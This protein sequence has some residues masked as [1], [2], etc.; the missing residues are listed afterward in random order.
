MKIAI[1]SDIH[2]NQ[3]AF[4]ALLQE[5][6]SLKV[7]YFFVLGDIVGYYYHPELIIEWIEEW[8]HLFIQGNHEMMLSR[9]IKG[10]LKEENIRQNYGSGIAQA[11]TN[12]PPATIEKLTNLPVTENVVIDNVRFQLSHGT[13]WDRDHY[14]YPD[15]PTTLLERC[16]SYEADFVFLGH[17]HRP[18]TFC[19]GNTVVTNVGSV[20][21]ARDKGGFASWV[22]VDTKNKA[23]QFHRTAY[24]ID[25]IL[26]QISVLDPEVPYLREVLQR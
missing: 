17:T 14:V 7:D 4:K 22:T 10:K 25:D 12:L 26:S 18:F 11:L 23:M 15:S 8:P 21:Q 6:R 2:G 19:S 5:A 20:G 24:H 16:A 3:V 9:V 13:P 1:V